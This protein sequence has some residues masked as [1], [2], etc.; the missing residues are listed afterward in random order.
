MLKVVVLFVLAMMGTSSFAL[1][2]SWT[3]VLG[4]MGPPGVAALGN[5]FS[6]AGTYT[7]CY[8]FDLSGSAGSFGGALELN[9]LLNSLEIDINSVAL[10]SPGGTQI[11][12]DDSPLAFSFGALAG[13]LGYTLAVVSEVASNWG[14]YDGKVGYVGG[15][16]TYASP[17][18]EPAPA[19]MLLIGMLGV[20]MASRRRRR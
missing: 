9:T 8:T 2:C 18:P 13:G 4:D 3:R 6:S 14:L 19:A 11:G 16:A 20:W 10:Y 12:Y 17:A 1:E 5:S 7:D 15:F